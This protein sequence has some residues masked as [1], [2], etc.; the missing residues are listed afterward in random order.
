MNRFIEP[1]TDFSFRYNYSFTDEAM[2]F[3]IGIVILI[4]FIAITAL[5]SNIFLGLAVYHDGKAKGNSNAGMW[6]VLSGIFG[7]IPAVI[8]LCVRHNAANRFI[9]CFSCGFAMPAN[10][11]GCPN[12][13]QA[14]PYAQQF[15]GPLVE[16]HKK[17]AKGFLIAF[18]CCCAAAIL[19]AIAV[20]VLAVL[21]AG[22][23][24]YSYYY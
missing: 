9:Q 24:G 13:N 4:I 14:N 12:C 18:I 6:G 20:I 3:A 2:G 16:Q 10:A 23:T 22:A 7:W 11:P 8:Y 5:L 21:F 15:Y 17:K 1:L 19:L